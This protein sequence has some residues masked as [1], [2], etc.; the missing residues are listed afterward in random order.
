MSI[1]FL[2]LFLYGL[3][4][5]RSP[6]L[7]GSFLRLILLFIVSPVA[8]HEP[9]HSFPPHLMPVFYH[10]HEEGH[11][12]REIRRFR[13]KLAEQLGGERAVRL[14]PH[15]G[16]GEKDEGNEDAQLEEA[17]KDEG[18]EDARGENRGGE[19]VLT[20][21]DPATCNHLV[22]E[23]TSGWG[24]LRIGYEFVGEESGGAWSKVAGGFVPGAAGLA[25]A[26]NVPELVAFLN[27][28]DEPIV[29]RSVGYLQRT[30]QVRRHTT[31][32]ALWPDVYRQRW[33]KLFSRSLL[34]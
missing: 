28:L 32:S 7:A 8:A 27:A 31:R 16:E 21:E 30:F 22:L 33:E 6:P 4:S 5:S 29:S 9:M 26:L 14:V 2:T 18:N 19:R 12:R 24:P 13:R 34:A 11:G 23:H 17:E 10:G 3:A 25:A 20:E 1:S 15:G